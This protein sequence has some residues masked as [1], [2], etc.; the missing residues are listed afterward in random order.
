MHNSQ[1]RQLC[2]ARADQVHGYRSPALCPMD[3]DQT[4]ALQALQRPAE[5]PLIDPHGVH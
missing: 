4:L 3:I 5:V 2:I 1:E